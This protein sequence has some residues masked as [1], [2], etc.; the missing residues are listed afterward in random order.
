MFA[1]QA[2]RSLSDD[3]QKAISAQLSAVK[4]K[5]PAIMPQ[6]V[7]VRIFYFAFRERFG[8][9]IVIFTC[10]VTLV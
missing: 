10:P 8:S 9:A 3:T 1:L 2:E 7:E 5:V 6:I 4:E